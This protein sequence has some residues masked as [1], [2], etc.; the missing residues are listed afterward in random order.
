MDLVVATRNQGK[1]K[2]IRRLLEGAQVRVLSLDEFPDLPEVEEDGETFSAN[3]QKKAETVARLTGRLTLADDSGLT[4]ATLGGAPGVHSA[5]Y[6]GPDA[7][8]E[9]NN[10]K[11]LE[12]LKGLPPSDRAGAFVCV[13]AL[14]TPEGECR[15]FDGRLEGTI[16][17]APRGGGG[18]G[19]D[20]VFLVS[21]DVRTLAELPMEA[22]N[23]VSHR[24]QALRKALEHLRDKL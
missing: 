18:F 5:R 7:G 12:A 15:F 24:G 19:Y 21:G 10:R 6:A 3:A 2:E 23:A 9:E 13:I 22:K 8:D 1:L 4:V 20:P 17:D 11:L 14:C 16:L